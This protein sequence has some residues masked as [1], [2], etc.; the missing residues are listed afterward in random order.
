MSAVFVG[1]TLAAWVGVGVPTDAPAQS[2]PL[3]VVIRA[4]PDTKYEEVAKVTQAVGQ[5]KA[6]RV[7][8]AIDDVP[9]TGLSAVIQ[10][11]AET[12]YQT[13]VDTLKALRAAGVHRVEGVATAEMLSSAQGKITLDGQ[14]LP[15]GRII[16]HLDGDQFV[17]AKIKADGTYKVDRVPVGR[18]KVTVEFKGVP[19]R[20]ASE[21][22]SALQVEITKGSSTLDFALMS[23]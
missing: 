3:T 8:L 13:V 2:T 7:K 20:Y 23:K 17:G 6:V 14:P 15:G 10:A 18:H 1:V 21:E 11:G 16:F 9:G 22:Q 5:D 19:A 4:R 12:R